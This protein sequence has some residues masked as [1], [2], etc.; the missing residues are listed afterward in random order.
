VTRVT[1]SDSVTSIKNSTFDGC[2]SLTSVTIGNSVTRI[3]DQ[4]F[5]NC[6]S[7]TSV[8]IGNSVTRIGDQAF[9]NCTS[10]TN[11]TIPNSVTDIGPLAFANCT[12]LT[13]LMIG[14]GITFVGAS[15]FSGCTSLN[16]VMVG[17]GVRSIRSSAFAGCTNIAAVYFQGNAPF[18]VDPSVFS[19]NATVYFLPGTTGWSGSYAGRPTAWWVLP[20][21]VILDFPPSFGVR[22]NGFGFTISW[23]TNLS[24]VVEGCSDLATPAWSPLATNALTGGWFQFIDLQW[25]NYSARFY[26]LR[27]P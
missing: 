4:A 1:I 21:P 3:G 22:T 26:R 18:A 16:Q 19:R 13:S 20:Y 23:A 11:I 12:S 15:A 6:T 9:H 27:S 5:Y 10:L 24:V 25:T 17:N 7:L 8:T 14:N 2:T